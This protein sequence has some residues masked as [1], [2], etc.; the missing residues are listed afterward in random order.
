MCSRVVRDVTEYEA[1]F[2]F[3]FFI[4]FILF[5]YDYLAFCDQLFYFY[6]E[7]KPV[8]HAAFEVCPLEIL[9]L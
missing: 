6:F 1:L 2:L 5:L 9:K 8:F 3:S 4:L 7:T